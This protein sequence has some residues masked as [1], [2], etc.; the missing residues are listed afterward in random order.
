[1]ELWTNINETSSYKKTER[2]LFKQNCLKRSLSYVE[3]QV[4]FEP[5]T[6]SLQVSCTTTVLLKPL[7]VWWG[8]NPRPP[9]PQPGTLPT[10]LQTPYKLQMDSNHHLQNRNLAC[11]CFNQQVQSHEKNYNITFNIVVCHKK[12]FLPIAKQYREVRRS[13]CKW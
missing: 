4:G 5:T 2:L 1:M 11:Y 9:E 12:H 6:C 7:G 13:Q 10:E 3:L 8:S